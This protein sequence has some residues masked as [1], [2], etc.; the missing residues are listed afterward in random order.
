MWAALSVIQSEDLSPWPA[1]VSIFSTHGDSI[2]NTQFKVAVKKEDRNHFNVNL[3]GR[4]VT[5]ELSQDLET[6][7]PKIANVENCECPFFKGDQ[8]M[9][10]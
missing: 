3:F 9:F 2:V 4:K 8:N 1:Q 5:S 6:G 7:C 10:R